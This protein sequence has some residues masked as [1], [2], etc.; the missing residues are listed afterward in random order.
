MNTSCNSLT[1][2]LFIKCGGFSLAQLPLGQAVKGQ[3]HK[4]TFFFFA[5]FCSFLLMPINRAKSKAPETVQGAG[6]YFAGLL[7]VVP[8]LDHV[9]AASGQG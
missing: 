4:Q 7:Q 1:Q 2:G 6:V 9:Q 3:S 5:Y 8:R